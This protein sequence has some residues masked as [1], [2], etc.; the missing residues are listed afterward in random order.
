MAHSSYSKAKKYLLS[1][2]DFHL[3]SKN[4]VLFNERVMV[5]SCRLEYHTFS[6]TSHYPTPS[7]QIQIGV[8]IQ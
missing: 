7:N 4:S 8:S 6:M 3:F 5:I 2:K 1:K